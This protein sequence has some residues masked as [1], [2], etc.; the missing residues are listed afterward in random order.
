MTRYHSP[1]EVKQPYIEKMGPELGAVFNE[2]WQEVTRLHIRWGEYV[3]LFGEKETRIRLLNDASPLFFRIVQDSLWEQIVLQIARLT[4][5]PEM[6]QK[7]NLWLKRLRGLIRE[8]TIALKVEGTIDVAM[9]RA[10]FVRDWRNRKL[11]HNDLALSLNQSAEALAPASRLA[12]KTSLK[13]IADVLNCIEVYY[14]GSTT[15][16]DVGSDGKGAE[17][18][19]YVINEGL[20]AVETRRKKIRE[21]KID[22]E[23]FRINQL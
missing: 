2:L 14:V 16:F 18:L 6:G 20:R 23:D 7:S 4:D 1:D 19:L 13:A 10:I 17:N 3:V 12:I 22:E 15:V 11:A 8:E 21:G 5:P 9:E